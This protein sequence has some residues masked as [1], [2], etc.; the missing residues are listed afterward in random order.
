MM[1]SMSSLQIA[2]MMF[3]ELLIEFPIQHFI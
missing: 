2:N 1:M 3:L